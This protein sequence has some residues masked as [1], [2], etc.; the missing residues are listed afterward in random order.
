VAWS[1]APENAG[2]VKIIFSNGIHVQYSG[3]LTAELIKQL[4]DA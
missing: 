4:G 1:S 2:F 3:E